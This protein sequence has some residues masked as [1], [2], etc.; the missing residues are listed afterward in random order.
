MSYPNQFCG[1][2]IF[3]GILLVYHAARSK[4]RL[5]SVDDKSTFLQAKGFNRKIYMKPA[6]WLASSR[7]KYWRLKQVVY[8][9][10]GA[11]LLVQL[12]IDNWLYKMGFRNI[13]VFEELFINYHASGSIQI[14]KA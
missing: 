8:G 3:D 10:L 13:P 14:L 7:K 2:P 4:R 9:L 5:T 12:T 1:H 6:P 11:P